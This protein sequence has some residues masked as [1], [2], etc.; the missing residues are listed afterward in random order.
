MRRARTF[1]A[2]IATRLTGRSEQAVRSRT[3]NAAIASRLRWRSEQAARSGTTGAAI[4]T[5]LRLRSEQTARE[6]TNSVVLVIGRATRLLPSC[7]DFGKEISSVDRLVDR[8]L[9]ANLLHNLSHLS[10]WCL[11]S[12]VVLDNVHLKQATAS[13]ANGNT[14]HCCY[15]ESTSPTTCW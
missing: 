8:F 4:A 13:A 10:L 14:Q 3:R 15:P 2:A 7:N 9:F 1:A 6:I 11:L 12:F 5:R